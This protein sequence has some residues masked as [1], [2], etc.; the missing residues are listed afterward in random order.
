MPCKPIRRTSQ[1]FGQTDRR[2]PAQQ[3]LGQ[4]DVGLTP[5][6]VIQWQGFEHDRGG[7]PRNGQHFADQFKD[8][9]LGWVANV[10]RPD[11]FGLVQCEKPADLIVHVAEAAG[12][13]S[14]AI[15]GERLALERLGQQ[16]GN[17]AA[18]MG[19]EPGP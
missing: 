19:P 16:V 5:R 18:V 2:L 1:S 13:G 11:D 3:P 8:G 4:R 15:D 17:D 12:L 10:D 14:V 7:G 9:D 6:R